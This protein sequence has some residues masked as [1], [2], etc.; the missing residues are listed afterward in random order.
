[1][2][3]DSSALEAARLLARD[4]LPGLV[5]TDRDGSPKAVLPASQVVRF[6]VPNYVLSDPSLARVIG[7]P[8][9]DR[10]ADRLSNAT[11]GELL[12]AKPQEL[13]VLQANDTVL[14]LAA[15]MARMRSPLCAVVQDG[16]IIG[17]VTASHLLAVMCGGAG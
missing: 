3:V 10:I 11:V 16:R 17:V 6:M 7:E 9:A 4:R 15:A 1:M 13:P 8:A 12:P 2:G 5:V 14:E